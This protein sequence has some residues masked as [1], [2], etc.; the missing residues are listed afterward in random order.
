M[1]V[2]V[3]LL[4]AGA[5]G[6][7]WRARQ[8]RI[9]PADTPTGLDTPERAALSALGV[10]PAAASVTLVQFSSAFCAPCRATRQ[11]LSAVAADHAGVTHVEVDAESHLDEVRAL[12]VRSTPTTLVVT[13]DGAIAGRAVGAPRRDQV[14][15]AVE[16]L[17]G[18]GS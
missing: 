15:A 10:D 2:A 4:A 8:G 16:P 14:E 18:A 13:P 1:L 7:L 11:V 17:L 9:R 3:L 5:G 6:W 12:D